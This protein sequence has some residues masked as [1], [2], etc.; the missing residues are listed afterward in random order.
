VIAAV[1]PGWA[2]FDI[3]REL[4]IDVNLEAANAAARV[5]CAKVDCLDAVPSATG[6]Q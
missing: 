2:H 1:P 5:S 4:S 6:E 3:A